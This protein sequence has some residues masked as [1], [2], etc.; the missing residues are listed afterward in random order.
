MEAYQLYLKGRALLYKRGTWI[1]PALESFRQAVDLDAG[2][3]DAWAGLA[4]AYTTQ[5]YYGFA[6]STQTLPRALDAARRAVGLDPVRRPRTA[7]SPWPRLL[8]DRDFETAE[9]EFRRA[10]DLNP[11]YTQAR[12]WYGLMFL[13]GTA[14][15]LDEGVEEARR[16]RRL[17]PLSG[18]AIA[19]YSYGLAQAHRIAEAVAQAQLAAPARSGVVR[20]GMD[21]CK[22]LPLEPSVR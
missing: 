16:R 7:R 21:V 22:R 8:W 4:D 12:C 3:A 6:P 5:A 2:Y 11:A 17:D 13:Q 15:R 14:H 1:A 18:Y 9:Q 19:C 10:L 20:R